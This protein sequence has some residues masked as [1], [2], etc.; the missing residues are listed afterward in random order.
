MDEDRD[1][2]GGRAPD[3][4]MARIGA[5]LALV[6]T[7]IFLLVYGAIA[8][9]PTLDALTLGII[10]G[11]SVTLLGLVVDGRLLGGPRS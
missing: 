7:V 8:G 2:A 5:A 9:H 11:T 10:L 1:D 6:A 4:R 3:Y